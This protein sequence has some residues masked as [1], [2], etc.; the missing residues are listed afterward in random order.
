MERDFLNDPLLVKQLRSGM[1]TVKVDAE[2]RPDLIAR[3]GIKLL[4]SDV[5]LD[6]NGNLLNKSTGPHDRPSYLSMVA[7]IDA[8]WGQARSE[9]IAYAHMIRLR[10]RRPSPGWLAGSARHPRSG[11]DASKT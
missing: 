8:R 3:F 1:V 9:R 6:P 7:R 2:K 10:R 4:P 5:F 11:H